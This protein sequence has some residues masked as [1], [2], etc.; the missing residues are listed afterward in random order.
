MNQTDG[1]KD[2]TSPIACQDY[3]NQGAKNQSLYVYSIKMQTI[4]NFK[5]LCAFQEDHSVQKN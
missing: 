1:S 2:E 3:V 5:V 4:Q